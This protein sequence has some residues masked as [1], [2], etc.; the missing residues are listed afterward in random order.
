[1]LA[2][3]V[4]FILLTWLLCAAACVG[5][6]S[7]FL[8]AFQRFDVPTFQRS[9]D[10]SSR[11]GHDDSSSSTFRPSD[12]PTFQRPSLLDSFWTGLALITAILQ[13]YHFF[14][15]IDS[16]VLI[17]LIALALA[18]L[19]WNYLLP[20]R[21]SS[22]GAP[23][24]PAP[25]ERVGSA[26]QS[27]RRFDVQTFR[28][29]DVLLFF[30]AA[31][32]IAFRSAAPTEHYDTGLYG[33]QAIRWFS[34]YPLLPGL[35]NVIGQ[36][37]FNSSIFLCMAALNHGPWRDLTHHFFVGF[38]LAA[39]FASIIPAALRVFRGNR[40]SYSAP[41]ATENKKVAASDWFLTFLFL[42][43]AIW[44][45]TGKLSGANTDLPTTVVCLAASFFLFRALVAA[46]SPLARHSER[47]EESLF[48]S[49]QL[50]LLIAMLLFSLA[51]TFKLSSLVFAFTGWLVS[52]FALCFSP[53]P[54]KKRF[55]LA[56]VIL[57]AA[58]VL[59]WICRGLILTGYPFFPST[60]LGIP[61]D[62]KVP[63][64]IAE[65]Q[66]D[67]ARSFA[68][69]PQIPLGDTSAFR[70]LRPWFRELIRE[71]EGFLIPLF[72]VL[73]GALVAIFKAK[74]NAFPR[75][76]WLLLPSLAGILFWFFEAPA[77]RFGE[78][79][80]WTAAATLGTFGALHLLDSPVKN[81]IFLFAL[82]LFTAWAA[83]PR[84]LWNSY[85][86]PSIDVRAFLPLPQLQVV[87]HR[88]AS[89]LTIYVP[90]ESN[91]CW[92]APLPCSP[93]FTDTL[94]LRHPGRIEDGFASGSAAAEPKMR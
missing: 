38:L 52:F 28:R 22:A 19:L 39:L 41:G 33:A 67:F 30:L 20:F 63:A 86:R 93:Y 2:V 91:Q 5:I 80:I 4:F 70:W 79:A 42:P 84:L 11:T 40:V 32:L 76:F 3:I 45:A 49:P 58:I 78:P 88:T 48:A 13:L 82:L 92:D 31:A 36:L 6:G 7:L 16:R 37:G 27:F 60:A 23:S 47:S 17:L 75:W 8:S 10:R 25:S 14:R 59:P 68:R 29:L 90:V 9:S 81:R 77:I 61:V 54:Q 72:F 71:R 73:A 50:S 83:H 46:P 57:S 62:W 1:M 53:T 43:T 26:L 44:A 21:Y 65:V 12:V 56:A 66:A 15:S 18:G 55:A 85:F 87:P 35:G 74:R 69:I 34:A 89:G 94:R 51:V 24:F 64:A